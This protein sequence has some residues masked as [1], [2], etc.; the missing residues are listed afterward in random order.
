MKQR[1]EG[2][3]MLKKE[4]KEV[5]G[6]KFYL[7]GIN[8]EG[9]KVWLQEATWECG[10]YWGI[11]YVEIFNKNYSDIDSHSHFN[12]MFLDLG[13]DIPEAFDGYFTETTLNDK[14]KWQLLDLM[15]SL[16]ICRE[17]A[18]FLK[19]GAYISS[20]SKILE[21]IK[22]DDERRRINEELIPKISKEV[23]NLLSK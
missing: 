6:R 21:L 19:H 5:F 12:Y 22:N 4:V 2:K 3:N 23:Y 13:K 8:Q 1:K 20:E 17:Y 7:L 15:E 10:W 14:E 18:D 16:Y 9:K 11:G